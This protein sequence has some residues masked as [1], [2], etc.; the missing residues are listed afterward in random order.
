METTPMT[1]VISREI[2]DQSK[3]SPDCFVAG[4]RSAPV[5]DGI[6]CGRRECGRHGH[7]DSEWCWSLGRGAAPPNPPAQPQDLLAALVRPLLNGG[8]S[9]PPNPPVGCAEY[10]GVCARAGFYSASAVDGRQPVAPLGDLVGN[11][12]D[13]SPIRVDEDVFHAVAV[14][15]Y[16]ELG[17]APQMPLPAEALLSLLDSRFECFE[18]GAEADDADVSTG[19]GRLDSTQLRA[20]FDDVRQ[21]EALGAGCKKVGPDRGQVLHSELDPKGIAWLARVAPPQAIDIDEGVGDT[22]LVEQFRQL[23]GN[24]GFACAYGAGDEQDRDARDARSL[25]DRSVRAGWP[26][27]TPKVVEEW[28]IDRLQGVSPE[29]ACVCCGRRNGCVGRTALRRPTSYGGALGFNKGQVSR[30][31]AARRVSRISSPLTPLLHPKQLVA[32]M[33]C[34]KR[35]YWL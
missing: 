31:R 8:C 21:Q 29:Y 11:G 35:C 18:S 13:G 20:R 3:P 33:Q 32:A 5:G 14:H 6:G 15:A 24:A 16:G 12:R 2:S 27:L 19:H 26:T 23:A 17:S 22:G 10:G 25:H 7:S 28:S 4:R 30:L 34:H 9:A 1:R